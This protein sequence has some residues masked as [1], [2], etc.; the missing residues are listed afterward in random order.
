VLVVADI[1]PSGSMAATVLYNCNDTTAVLQHT[2]I[3]EPHI[4]NE[5][6]SIMFKSGPLIWVYKS[7]T[8][9][10]WVCESRTKTTVFP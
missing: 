1:M 2:G 5:Q 3:E 4:F 6:G 8:S 7:S 9:H 10:I